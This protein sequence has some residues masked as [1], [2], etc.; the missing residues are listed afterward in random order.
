MPEL[1]SIDSHAEALLTATNLDPLIQGTI[2]APRA[3]GAAIHHF[4]SIPSTNG[5]AMQAAATGAQEGTIFI[6]E[7]Q[8]AG[9]GRGGHTWHSA[10]SSGIYLSVILRPQLAPTE[11]LWLSL[12]TGLAAHDAVRSQTGIAP[13]LRWPN[14]VMLGEKKCGGIL[15]ELSTEQ[16]KVRHVVV[17]IG[18]NVNHESFPS[19]LR[20]LATSLRVETGRRWP[21]LELAAALLK[22]LDREYAAFQ[23]NADG[24]Y[25]E[26]ILA[27][28][29]QCSS[30]VRSA[31]VQVQD[32]GSGENA[33]FTGTTAGLD[34]R[35]FL[36]VE[37]SAG[38]RTVISGGV[39]KIENLKIEDLKIE[40]LKSKQE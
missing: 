25:R 20:N 35:G 6:G 8:T 15:T 28:F 32:S 14:D 2:F 21:R 9:R 34:K 16:A 38:L 26:S 22:S 12:I 4:L 5:A 11:T 19:E 37:T 39:R 24:S 36:L 10:A 29:E 27:R 1:P 17:G 3:G 18:L 33:S 13:D 30:Y 7:E 31:K 40:D 23:A